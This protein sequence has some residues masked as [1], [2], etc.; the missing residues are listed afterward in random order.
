MIRFDCLPIFRQKVEELEK[1]VEK[2]TEEK[3]EAL[4]QMERIDI[5]VGFCSQQPESAS[6]CCSLEVNML[7]MLHNFLF[8]IC[9]WC[10]EGGYDRSKT[11]VFHYR[12]NPYSMSSGNQR[13]ELEHLREENVRLNAKLNA[14]KET[15]G[16][17]EGLSVIADENVCT[18]KELQ[19]NHFIIIIITAPDFYSLW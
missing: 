18:T 14:I 6:C 13:Q 1:S 10:F 12:M 15:G 9:C 3:E 16:P 19:G 7:S 5:Q 4:A 2:Q 8:C 11:R 17:V